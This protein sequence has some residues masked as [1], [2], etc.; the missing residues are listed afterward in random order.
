MKKLLDWFYG[1]IET[2]S[3]KLNSWAW[4]KRWKHRD[5]QEWV[6]GYKKWKKE[7]CPHN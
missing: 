3:G 6:K 7:R 5:H 2:Y 1:I 4:D